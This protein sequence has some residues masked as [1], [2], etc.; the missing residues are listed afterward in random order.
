LIIA[1]E[2]ITYL[3]SQIHFHLRKTHGALR[4]RTNKD[5]REEQHV[6]ILLIHVLYVTY[7]MLAE[8]MINTTLIRLLLPEFGSL[9]LR[10][11]FPRSSK[12]LCHCGLSQYGTAPD[13][14]SICF[15]ISFNKNP[16]PD[17]ITGLHNGSGWFTMGLIISLYTASAAAEMK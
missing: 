12:S 11:G 2:L 5:C 6:S 17:S 8:I 9:L 16:N 7:A 15:V 1:F 14:R 10:N 3:F 4:V 13:Q